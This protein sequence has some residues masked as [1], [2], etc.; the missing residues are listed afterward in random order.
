MILPHLSER[1]LHFLDA[2]RIHPLMSLEQLALW[3]GWNV[4]RV[5]VYLTQL[6][7]MG[8]VYAINP[9]HPNIPVQ[10]LWALTLA[11]WNALKQDAWFSH[12]KDWEKFPYTRTRLEWLVL[13]SERVY[14]IRNFL[15]QLKRMQ[16]DWSL[17]TWNVEVE[18]Q[19]LTDDDLDTDHTAH[20]SGIAQ[21]KNAQGRWI[22]LAIE[23]DTNLMHVK[24]ER[25]RLETF[26][27]S[28]T[29]SGFNDPHKYLFPICVVIAA[30]REREYEYHKLLLELAFKLGWLMPY[31]FFIRREHLSAFYDDPTAEVWRSDERWTVGGIPFLD[32]IQGAAKQTNLIDWRALP[33]RQSVNDQHIELKPLAVGVSL[34]H[35]RHDLAA[36]TLALYALDKQV[37]K[38]L[39]DH[40]LLDARELAFILQMPVRSIRR[41]LKRLR[42]LSL[43]KAYAYRRMSD[44]MCCVLKDKG[45][46]L[47]TA[48][49]GLGTAIKT[50]AHLRGWDEGFG[51]LI[52]HWEHTRLENQIYLQFSREARERGHTLML[53]RS[54]LE[55][56]IYSEKMKLAPHRRPRPRSERVEERSEIVGGDYV[57]L[58]KDYGRNMARFLPDG[59]GV[60]VAGKH[61]Y[62]I[63]VEVDRSKANNRKMKVKLNYYNHAVYARDD[64]TWRILIV[65]TGWK[66]ARHLADLVLQDALELLCGDDVEHLRGEALVTWLKD[67]G[68]LKWWSD[69]ILPVFITT[70]DALKEHGVA[71]KIWGN[72]WNAIYQENDSRVYCLECF[73]PKA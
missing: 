53:W 68:K 32:Q 40:P 24:G 29:L 21:L 56:Q 37:L 34:T 14:H 6:R 59:S 58:L 54:E 52:K 36:I 63:A 7:Q 27:R 1:Q 69:S 70:I 4:R 38:L 57:P 15:L 30:N 26:V 9:R 18:A 42:K 31:T 10:S 50:Y 65:T 60:Y 72:A 44:P 11:G 45:I 8:L 23:Y 62:V 46:W 22:T 28:I 25:A 71:G 49:A 66:R 41:S 16:W 17:Q 19:F 51:G 47:L 35:S 55:S 13:Q 12:P 67:A 64:V 43:V 48:W 33:V 73:Q 39:A 3:L 2:I 61:H 20:L 5:Q